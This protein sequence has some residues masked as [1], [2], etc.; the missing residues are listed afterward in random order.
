M[1]LLTEVME[2]PLDPGYA[3]AAGRRRASGPAARGVTLL[4]ALATGVLL[5]VAVVAVREPLRQ[6]TRASDL[7]RQRIT[8]RTRLVEN[9]QV[10]NARLRA[11][12]A[13]AQE[14]ALGTG[15]AGLT[16]EVR[17]LGI[18]TGELPVFGPGLRITVSD[19]AGSRD[20]AV[21]G[22]PRSRPAE[23]GLVS[24]VD[25]QIITNGLWAA[26]AEAVA[27]NGQ[28]LTSL[29]AIRSAGEAILVDFRPL[30]PPYVIEAIG[31][32]VGMQA[33]F[34]S[35]DAGT[36]VQSMRDNDKIAVDVARRERLALPGAGQLVLR[37]ARPV[38]P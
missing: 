28:R 29:S 21:G 12:I 11:E 7:I 26:G 22:D 10:G 16:A 33:G 6:T 5:S 30:A 27:V 25:L 2:R 20:E 8:E 9:R 1:T 38:T 23:A 32:T 36:Y 35:G 3:A 18:R 15:G 37:A 24:D 17:R 13:R 34:A 31:D 4:L 19:A 14:A